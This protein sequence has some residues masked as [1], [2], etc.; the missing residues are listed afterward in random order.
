MAHPHARIS[1]TKEEADAWLAEFTSLETAAEYFFCS[2]P[3]LTEA[4]R[5]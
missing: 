2:T 5:V 4:M 3:I 1:L